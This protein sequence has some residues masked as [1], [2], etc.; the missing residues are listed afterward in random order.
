MIIDSGSSLEEIRK[1]AALSRIEAKDLRER[2][3]KC[4]ECGYQIG[5]V[6]SDAKGHIS[7]K[8]QKCKTVSVLN[9]AYF[10]KQHCRRPN[11]FPTAYYRKKNNKI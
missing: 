2:S 6:F 5:V 4:P 9:L 3:I 11:M 8:C 7:V 10:R 1:K